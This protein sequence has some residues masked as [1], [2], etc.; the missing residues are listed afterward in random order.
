MDRVKYLF[1][2]YFAL[3]PLYGQDVASYHIQ[4]KLGGLM[5]LVMRSP[6]P[7]LGNKYQKKYMIGNFK[8]VMM[9]LDILGRHYYFL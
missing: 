6:I 8:H 4:V 3:S 2:R 1:L 5:S 7:N 9:E